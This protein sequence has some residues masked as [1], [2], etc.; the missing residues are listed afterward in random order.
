MA[1]RRLYTAHQQM[2]AAAGH[3]WVEALAIATSNDPRGS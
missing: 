1:S 3:L 2:P